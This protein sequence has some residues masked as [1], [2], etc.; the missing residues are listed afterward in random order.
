M[1]FKGTVRDVAI[2]AGLEPYVRTYQRRHLPPMQ[3]RDEID[4]RNM[5]LLMKFWLRPDSSCIDIGANV[6]AVLR[7]I[8]T[9][10]PYGAHHAFE[11][12]VDHARSLQQAFPNVVVHTLALADQSGEVEFTRV[13]EEGMSGYSGFRPQ[14]YPKPL[15]TDTVN[16]AVARLDDCLPPD[17]APTFVKIDVEGA[18]RD[19]I[20]GGMET[21]RRHQPLVVFEHFEGGAGSYGYGPHEIYSL[22]VDDA[23]YDILDI[24]G[25]GPY[26]LEQMSEVFDS[27][28]LWTWVARPR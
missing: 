1:S 9:I 5:A 14:W 20:A 7:D 15:K 2:K 27:R 19:V 11:P 25:N 6:G 18:E 16:V 22:L 24:D 8:V 13:L 28:L 21:L 23:G 26:S 3:L 12:L 10:A 4:M 17:Y